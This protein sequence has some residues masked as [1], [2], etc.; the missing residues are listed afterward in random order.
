MAPWSSNR[1]PSPSTQ[2]DTNLAAPSNVSTARASRAPSRITE[3]DILDNALLIP[4]LTATSNEAQRKT[5]G[6]SSRPA[7]TPNHGRSK[8][9][10]FPSLFSSKKKRQGEGAGMDSTDDDSGSSPVLPP[11]QNA[12]AKQGKIPEKDLTTG[13][14]M[15]CDS[16]VRWP[17]DLKVFRCTVC[18]TIND[19][20]PILLEA[21]RGDGHR[22]PVVIQPGTSPPGGIYYFLVATAPTD[23]LQYQDS[24][25]RKPNC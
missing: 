2:N 25:S 20:K 5:S 10:P 24:Q 17:K 23:E 12:S 1:L 6:G 13:R 22:A 11:K 14:C 9:H 4:T 7:R 18:L 8:S 19:L 21:R 16:M 3:E 15:T